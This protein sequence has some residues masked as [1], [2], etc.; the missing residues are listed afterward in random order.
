MPMSHQD[1]I[2]KILMEYQLL[3]A[4][5]EAL[6]RNYQALLQ[7]EHALSLRYIKIRELVGSFDTDMGGTNRFELTEQ[8]VRELIE[9]ASKY[10][11]LCK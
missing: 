11:Q 1:D 8:K 10:D 2:L 7:A 6:Y 3:D 4:K 5:H 9:K